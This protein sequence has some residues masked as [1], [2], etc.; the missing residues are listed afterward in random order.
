[1]DKILQNKIGAMGRWGDR[2]E[3]ESGSRK[4]ITTNH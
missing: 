4:R 3:W 2:E 1:M